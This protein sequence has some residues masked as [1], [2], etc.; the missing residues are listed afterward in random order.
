MVAQLGVAY[1][2][3]TVLPNVMREWKIAPENAIAGYLEPVGVTE[4]AS[5]SVKEF[6]KT[7][8][9]GLGGIHTFIA[10]GCTQSFARDAES[11]AAGMARCYQDNH[12]TARMVEIFE[13][14][15]LPSQTAGTSSLQ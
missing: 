2:V 3:K 9:C 15:F 1:H 8:R 12:C 11:A 14:G 13:S 5:Q 4:I 6:S 7:T 10:T